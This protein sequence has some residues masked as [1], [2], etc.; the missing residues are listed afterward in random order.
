[1]RS[2]DGNEVIAFQW[3]IVTMLVVA[4]LDAGFIWFN[5]NRHARHVIAQT[6]RDDSIFVAGTAFL[7]FEGMGLNLAQSASGAAETPQMAVLFQSLRTAVEYDG[8]DSPDARVLREQILT[9]LVPVWGRE[10]AVESGRRTMVTVLLGDG[11]VYRFDENGRHGI[12]LPPLSKLSLRAQQELKLVNAPVVE[13][14]FTG[15]QASAPVFLHAGRNG[16]PKGPMLGQI[17]L[18][19]G[20]GALL[21]RTKDSIGRVVKGAGGDVDFAFFRL[22]KD[23]PPVMLYTTGP[24]VVPL[25]QSAAFRRG[26]LSSPMA[27]PVELDDDIY[28]LLAVPVESGSG[29]RI[30][31]GP[32]GDGLLVA[33]SQMN[34][35]DRAI[36]AALRDS[37]FWGVLGY[38]AIIA[39]IFS[40]WRSGSQRLRE[41]IHERT[42][43]LAT[44]V[45]DLDRA[46]RRYRGMYENAVQGMFQS[47]DSRMI[48]ANPAMARILG[49]GSVRE[50]LE[51][52]DINRALYFEPDDRE[53]WAFPLRE[54][55]F[56]QNFEVRHKRKDGKPVWLLMNLR[57]LHGERGEN[58]YEGIAVDNTA[59]RQAETLR[60]EIRDKEEQ[61]RLLRADKMAALGRLMAGIAHE[62]N[63]PN[64]FVTFNI[65]VLREYLDHVERVLRRMAEAEPGLRVGRQPYRDFL[66]DIR[67]LL[68]DM[69]HGSER[70]TGIVSQ[71]KTYVR[72]HEEPEKRPEDFPEAVRRV[73]TLV[74]KEM[75]RT[76]RR[77]VVDVPDDLPHVVMH[78]GKIEQVLVNLLL[79]AS[80]AVDKDDSVVELRA[81][82][83]ERTPGKDD[84]K[85]IGKGPELGVEVRVRDNGCGVR[86]EV[87]ERMFDPF[88]TT[89]EPDQ[90]TGLGLSIAQRIIE[91][92][93]GRIEVEST[94]GEGTEFRFVLPVRSGAKTPDEPD[95]ADGQEE[96]A[97]A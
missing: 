38:A 85:R 79:N 39:A 29:I 62:I 14:G 74:G 71:L 25:T 60:E 80:Q 48:S 20:I 46:E 88:F 86:P 7:A 30:D 63:N 53:E 23:G 34:D 77:F 35:V 97:E 33:W 75:D 81:R 31:P 17:D 2:R 42:A 73:V 67:Q 12:G 47:T 52:P 56:I 10:N 84:A 72:G 51:I 94:P 9:F 87:R 19:V 11:R 90:G 21:Q 76:V 59:L 5:Y 24:Q 65:P 43:E 93:G 36:S 4:V 45:E 49:Y 58:V 40:L 70:I 32:P 82:V 50:L 55:G 92:H 68:D 16:N 41:M 66:T 89:K 95:T 1:M 13:P 91:E 8:P 22:V 64:N 96:T 26:L 69:E 78:S 83:V 28:S 27:L 57:H 6:V 37:V 18:G 44:A 15:I 54:M 3:F 61:Q